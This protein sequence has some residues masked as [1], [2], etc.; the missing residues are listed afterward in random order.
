MSRTS[1]NFRRLAWLALVATLLMSAMPTVSRVLM[2]T[3]PKAVPLLM[4]ICTMAGRQLI[5]VSP[6]VAAEESPAQPSMVMMDACGYCVLATP[7]PLV[8]L[9]FCLL[10]LFPIRPPVVR[11]YLACLR[12][13]R[14]ARGL[15]SQAPP[16]AL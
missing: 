7:L 6:F 10:V 5:D 11:D 3:A 9:L 16:L 15:G 8:L 13:P 12:W 4:E 14:N 2:A 1:A